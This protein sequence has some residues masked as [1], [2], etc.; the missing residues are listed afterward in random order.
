MNKSG[1]LSPIGMLGL[2][3]ILTLAFVGCEDTPTMADLDAY[4]ANNPYISDPRIAAAEK[5][6]DTHLKKL[7]LGRSIKLIPPK[8]FE[9][10]THTLSLTFDNL[11]YLKELQ[12]MLNQIIQHPSFEIIV[13]DKDLL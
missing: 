5:N 8:D 10:N 9:G 7:K 2:A 3:L 13:E 4:F 12:S 1:F 6:Y 11:A